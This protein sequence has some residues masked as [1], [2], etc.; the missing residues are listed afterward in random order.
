VAAGTAENGRDDG[1]DIVE[2]ALKIVDDETLAWLI[3][4]RQLAAEPKGGPDA[5]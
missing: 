2:L 5:R 3:S 4:E 1:V